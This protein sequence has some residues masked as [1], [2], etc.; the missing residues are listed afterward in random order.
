MFASFMRQDGG[1][2]RFCGA[3]NASL[4]GPEANRRLFGELWAILMR[5]FDEEEEFF[6]HGKH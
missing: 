4:L 5:A 3:L 2:T 6:H 1:I